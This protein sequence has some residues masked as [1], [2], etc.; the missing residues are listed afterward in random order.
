MIWVHPDDA[1]KGPDDYKNIVCAEFPNKDTDPELHE[2]VRT[3]MVHG[4]CGSLSEDEPPVNPSA[5]CMTKGITKKSCEKGFPKRFSENYC[6]GENSE[7]IYQRRSKEMGGHTARIY[8]SALK[9]EIEIDNRFVVPYNRRLLLKY[10]A[11]INFE[12]VASYG[13]IKYLFKYIHKGSD[14]II[15]E[16]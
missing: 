4:P 11:H 6:S 3:L 5:P 7:P 14:R 15:V 9:E 2:L 8:C 10:K 16:K 12:I 13:A 1:P